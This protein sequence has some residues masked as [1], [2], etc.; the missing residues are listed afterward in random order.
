MR[1]RSD[2]SARGDEPIREYLA[3][4]PTR[5]RDDSDEVPTLLG[6]FGLDAPVSQRQL[7]GELR[8]IRG[9]PSP[10]AR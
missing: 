2:R 6:L 4:L 1:I 5:E 3:A 7:D 9:G 8:E 10:G